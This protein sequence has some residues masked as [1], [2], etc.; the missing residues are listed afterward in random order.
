M[1]KTIALFIFGAIITF[2]SSVFWFWV[3]GIKQYI[4]KIQ[5]ELNELKSEIYKDFQT[6]DDAQQNFHQI[7]KSLDGIKADIHRLNDKLDRKADK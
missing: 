7:M 1:D 5:D 3:K 6:K 2:I 4:N